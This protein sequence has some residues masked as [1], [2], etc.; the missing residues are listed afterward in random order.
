MMALFSWNERMIFIVLIIA[1]I[2]THVAAAPTPR[3][4]QCLVKSIAFHGDW[5]EC[6]GGQAHDLSELKN[7]VPPEDKRFGTRNLADLILARSGIFDYQEADLA[8]FQICRKHLS[9]LGIGWTDIRSNRPEKT[10]GSKRYF[11]CNMPALEGIAEHGSVFAAAGQHGFVTKLQANA[12]WTQKH[13]IV[14]VG[15]GMVV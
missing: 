12:I 15:T 3:P 8:N 13:V 5:T 11:K 7:Q 4:R 9:E 2:A 14:P 1:V 6:S 10:S